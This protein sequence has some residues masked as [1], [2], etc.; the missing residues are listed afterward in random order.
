MLIAINGIP[1]VKYSSI[2]DLIICIKTYIIMS[3]KSIK[4]VHQNSLVYALIDLNQFLS[5][6]FD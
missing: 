2:V 3:S 1:H 5:K 4:L 6:K